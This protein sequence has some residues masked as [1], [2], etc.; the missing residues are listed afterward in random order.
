MDQ[1]TAA[2]A[3]AVTPLWVLEK[4]SVFELVTTWRY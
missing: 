2:E 4:P 1:H 3:P